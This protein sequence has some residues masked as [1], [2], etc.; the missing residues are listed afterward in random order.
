LASE[1]FNRYSLSNIE[2]PVERS[3][4]KIGLSQILSN[5]IGVSA[6][7]KASPKNR[8]ALL[9]LLKELI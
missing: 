9:F 4:L 6:I 7:K 1:G 2:H 8:K 5:S 3:E